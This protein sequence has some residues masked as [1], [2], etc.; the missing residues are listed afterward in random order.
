[1]SGYIVRRLVW[2]V[3]VVLG[4]TLIVFVV[5]H[6]IP[7]DP[8]TIAAGQG[9]SADSIR[10]IREEFGLDRPLHEQYWL[11]LQGLFRG[12]L[13]RSILTGRPVLDDIRERFPATLELALVATFVSVVLGV[14]L[15][16]LSAVLRDSHTDNAIR[17]LSL[18]WVGMPEFWFALMLQIIFFGKLGLLPAGGRTAIEVA[19]PPRVTGMFT[20]D[21]LLAL[22]F[23]TFLNVL[24][25]LVLPVT[26]LAL[27]RMAELVRITRSGMLEVLQQD[28][29][30]TARAK[31][32]SGR[33]VLFGHAL[34]N[35]ALP[36]ITI[37]G[38]QFGYLLGGTVLIEAIFLWP[39]IGRYAVHSIQNVDFQ[40]VMGVAVI[41][42]ALFVVVNLL[43]DLLY[44]AVDPRIRY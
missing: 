9:A 5:T 7:A 13:G 42:S 25:H 10:A 35:A 14:L 15:G 23:G 28:Y 11:Y 26:A 40:A 16:T 24:K 34:K 20:V 19:A 2:L 1:M 41:L 17:V 12:N 32:L 29:V 39:G 33:S 21:A 22:D 44:T 4:M 3:F 38:I 30:R 8:A 18:L 36:I 31:G 6:L 43:V 37:V 27:V